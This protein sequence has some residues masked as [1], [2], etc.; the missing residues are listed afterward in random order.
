MSRAERRDRCGEETPRAGRPGARGPRG[1]WPS[2]QPRA[3]ARHREGGR[4][5]RARPA[6]LCPPRPAAAGTGRAAPNDE[7]GARDPTLR[8]PTSAPAAGKRRRKKINGLK[9]TGNQN[10]LDSKRKVVGSS[11]ARPPWRRA[12]RATGEGRAQGWVSRAPNGPCRPSNPI[13]N[14]SP[15][16]VPGASSAI[17]PHGAGDARKGQPF[18]PS[19][20]LRPPL[21]PGSPAPPLPRPPAPSHPG[22]ARRVPPKVSEGAESCGLAGAYLVRRARAAAP[23]RAGAPGA[24][25]CLPAGCPLHPVVASCARPAGLG[26]TLARR[27]VPRAAA[28][29]YC[30]LLAG[31][32][33]TLSSRGLPGPAPRPG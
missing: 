5:R 26:R 20:R 2:P 21:R 32:G 23:G 25:A 30:P 10:W 16:S 22:R 4:A 13:L 9:A 17:P 33:A 8:A 19:P 6:P 31:R 11:P 18:S 15:N 7:R 24:A 28:A 14:P 29:C 1:P 12:P 27:T 3:N